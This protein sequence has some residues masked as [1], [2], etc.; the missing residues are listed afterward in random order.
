MTPDKISAHTFA[1]SQGWNVTVRTA[2]DGDTSRDK[3]E[4]LD[5]VTLLYREQNHLLAVQCAASMPLS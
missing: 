3:A 1:I 4:L 2:W 5:V